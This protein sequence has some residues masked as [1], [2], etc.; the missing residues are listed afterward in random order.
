MNTNQRFLAA[1]LAILGLIL[2][3]MASS[4]GWIARNSAEAQS[5][6]GINEPRE[7]STIDVSATESTRVTPDIGSAVF[8]VI[9]GDMDAAACKKLNDTKSAATLEAIKAVEIDEK[10]IK[11]ESY[12]LTPKQDWK[13]GET[14]NAGYEAT[15]VIK[16]RDIA[17]ANIG[18]VIDAAVTGGATQVQGVSY[19]VSN[20][21]DSYIKAIEAAIK[22]AKLNA[23]AIAAATGVTITGVDSVSTLENNIPKLYRDYAAMSNTEDA[24]TGASNVVG[25]PGEIEITAS[26]N[27]VYTIAN[28]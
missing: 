15:T 23:D 24:A 5:G 22:K 20:A 26:V 16:V 21:N 7:I 13:D 6:N 9:S 28:N 25:N 10:S 27:I 2:V 18:K 3:Y 4:L 8:W 19:T 11:V 12:T 1:S 14:I 17:V